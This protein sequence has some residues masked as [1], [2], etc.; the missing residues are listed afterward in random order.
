[1][2]HTLQNEFLAI[3]LDLPDEGYHFS[4]FDWTGKI[5]HV[6]FKGIP[7]TVPEK[8]NEPREELFGKGLYNEFGIEAPV[9]FDEV[10]VGEWFHK[11]GVGLLKKDSSVYA[12]H[13]PYETRPASFEFQGNDQH[14]KIVCTSE[15]SNG[16]AYILNKEI[17]L[18][19]SS[20]A[21]SYELKNTGEKAIQT[22]EYV[23]NFFGIAGEWM[24]KD[25][26]LSFPFEL[27][28]E[29]FGANVNPEQKVEIGDND[30]R[31]NGTPSEPFF[32]SNLTGG[33]KRTALW[34]LTNLKHGIKIQESTDFPT[35]K[36]NL[37][38][39]Q[40]V[41]SPELFFKIDLKAGEIVR[42][43]RKYNFGEL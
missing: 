3:S 30:I 34:T 42:W 17:K 9:G 2:P 23:H 7:M 15:V 28:A 41:I 1:M 8:Q 16:Y 20:L 38:G 33:E 35:D 19:G 4:R 21:I 18:E 27:K 6:R 29:G 13:H 43:T 36:I 25:D 11:I 5:T 32:F 24:G 22:D 26:E 14:M 31:F 37:W 12:F 40:H 39:T 10:E